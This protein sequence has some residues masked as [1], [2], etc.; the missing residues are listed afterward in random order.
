V[1]AISREISREIGSKYTI[2]SQTRF[3]IHDILQNKNH[4]IINNKNI[5]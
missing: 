3:I 5:I 4:N 1:D 2:Y